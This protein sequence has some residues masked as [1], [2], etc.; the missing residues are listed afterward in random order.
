[1]RQTSPTPSGCRVR[2]SQPTEANASAESESTYSCS[3]SGSFGVHTGYRLILD[4]KA[5]AY[6]V[7]EAAKY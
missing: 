2:R 5:D 6:R 4:P 1:M 7:E 3:Y